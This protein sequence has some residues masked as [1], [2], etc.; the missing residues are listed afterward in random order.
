MIGALNLIQVKIQKTEDQI[1][2][3]IVYTQAPILVTIVNLRCLCGH[4]IIM[5]SQRECLCCRE[6]QV[7]LNKLSDTDDTSTS[8]SQLRCITEHPGFSSV[9]LNIWVL[10]A[11]YSQYRQH[12]GSYIAPL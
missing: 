9:C 8:G 7:I 10:Q 2:H 12:Y 5:Q 11:V 3:G 4:C 6:I 1:A